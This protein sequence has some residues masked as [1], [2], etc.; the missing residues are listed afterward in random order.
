M[1]G[2]PEEQGASHSADLVYLAENFVFLRGI[3]I[4][5]IEF[6][7]LNGNKSALVAS[8]VD[9]RARAWVGPATVQDE[10]VGINV[11]SLWREDSRISTEGGSKAAC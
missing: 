2:N 4:S 7:F 9:R 10:I 8:L 11:K 6:E 1:V 3:E 5:E